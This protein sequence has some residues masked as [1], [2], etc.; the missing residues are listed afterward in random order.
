[1]NT[2]ILRRVVALILVALL[3]SPPAA[4]T[5]ELKKGTREA[6]DRY[7]RVRE[8]Q[9][10]QEVKHNPFL[11]V[12]RQPE[13]KRVEILAELRK[14]EVFIERLRMRDEKGKE[15]EAPGGLIHH[16][17]G[18][19]FIPGAK[20]GQVI[21]LVQDY[22]NHARNYTPDMVLSSILE[23]K[24]DCFQVHMRFY[25]KKLGFGA[26]IDNDQEA[27]YFPASEKRMHS[28]ARTT[29]VQQVVNYGQANQA[30]RPVGSD[31][32][33]MWALNTYWMFEERDGGV[34]MQC[35][36][37]SL[38]RDI[39]WYAQLFRTFITSVPRES[40]MF[41]LGRTRDILTKKYQPK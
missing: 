16:W 25:K 36:A 1:M 26:V 22:N 2:A 15:I 3:L 27:C 19:V 11:W 24:D 41:S 13:K 4:A 6:F 28:R 8:A 9:V 23:H 10:D 18:T 32:G 40:L 33:F 31:D 38:S 17:L 20:V 5:E 14:G 12:D 39:P 7:V 29:R 37:I 34:Y 21:A 30:L 35:E